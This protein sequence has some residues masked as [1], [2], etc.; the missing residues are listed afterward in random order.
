[1]GRGSVKTA[2][3]LEWE[4]PSPHAVN[5]VSLSSERTAQWL[6]SSE[7]TARWATGARVE[8]DPGGR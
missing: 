5:G 8:R 1:M 6:F 3:L 7:G 2:P 4:D